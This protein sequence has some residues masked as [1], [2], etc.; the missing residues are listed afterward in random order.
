MSLTRIFGNG[1]SKGDA[2][3]GCRGALPDKEVAEILEALTRQILDRR[4][5]CLVADVD[6][7]ARRQP[8]Q[9]A[10]IQGGRSRLAPELDLELGG[11]VYRLPGLLDRSLADAGDGGEPGAQ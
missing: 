1:V 3:L 8:R 10:G 2:A 4:R 6:V 9:N 7:E 11:I 5:G